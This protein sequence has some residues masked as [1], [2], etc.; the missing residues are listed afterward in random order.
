MSDDKPGTPREVRLTEETAGHGINLGHPRAEGRGHAGSGG[1]QEGH[2]AAA[3][4]DPP[5]PPPEP[6][7]GVKN[8]GR[9]TSPPPPPPADGD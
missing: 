1:L 8:I 9:P 3:S 5:P 6:T 7:P 2:M 4:A